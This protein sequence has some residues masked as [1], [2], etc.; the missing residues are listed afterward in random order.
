M[1]TPAHSDLQRW[2]PS[3]WV[4]SA[5]FSKKLLKWGKKKL[6]KVFVGKKACTIQIIF[7]LDLFS[8]CN[9]NR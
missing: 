8:G 3:T 7:S 2:F 6:L 4:G 9:V 5:A 1:W